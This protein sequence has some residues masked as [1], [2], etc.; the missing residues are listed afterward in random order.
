M[1]IKINNNL[2]FNS[3]GPPLL[4]A[5]ISANHCGSKKK[6]L[7]H[8]LK[9]KKSGADLVKIQTYEVSD[10][11]IN[12]KFKIKSGAWKGLNISHLYK[13]AQTP[14]EWHYDAFK[15]AKKNKICLFSTPFSLRALSF[16]KKFNPPIYKVASFEITHIPL[17][18][19]IAK[20]K[21]PVIL[22][23]GMANINEISKAIKTLKKNGCNKIILLHCVS[24]YPA[25]IRSC[26]LRSI[27]FLSDKFNCEVGWSDHT[28]NSLLVF[29]AITNFSA[30]YIEFHFDLNDGKGLESQIG[31]C[32]K[33]NEIYN[34]TNYIKNKKIIEGKLIKKP[35]INE[36]KERNWRTD[37]SDGLRP[38]KKIRKKFK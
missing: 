27:K 11:T 20:T 10:M 38:L 33:P 12:N 21:K 19:K 37:P 6:F 30:K 31:H 9:A 5:E 36:I 16:L 35:N 29:D 15:L 14:F 28:K 4:I 13:K 3:E 26:N 1:K 22:S 2:N 17:L 18:K 32:W 34:L 25:D 23:T 8:I 24:Q 7:Q